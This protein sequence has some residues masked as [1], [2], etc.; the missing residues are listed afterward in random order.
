MN[1]SHSCYNCIYSYI[2]NGDKNKIA[3]N[4]L[5]DQIETI[6]IE[7][8]YLCCGYNQEGVV[9]D[10]ERPRCKHYEEKL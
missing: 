1:K 4:A 10:D 2:T 8:K 7:K 5:S 6:S 9:L 3:Y